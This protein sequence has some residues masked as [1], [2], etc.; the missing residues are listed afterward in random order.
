[1]SC[2]CLKQSWKCGTIIAATSGSVSTKDFSRSCSTVSG[3][4]F[5][6]FSY[7]D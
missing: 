6:S 7:V 5:F 1:V 3:T 2:P 4:A